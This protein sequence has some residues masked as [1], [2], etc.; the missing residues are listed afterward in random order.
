[1]QIGMF[2][3]AERVEMEA[4]KLCLLHLISQ[5]FKMRNNV[6]RTKAT[7][8]H[9]SH[10]NGQAECQR[11]QRKVSIALCASRT[12]EEVE[13]EDA[14]EFSKNRLPQVARSWTQLVRTQ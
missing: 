2:P 4:Q 7:T 9:C 6:Q 13:D 12:T 14:N 5:A 11:N 3:H 8:H 10:K 1:M